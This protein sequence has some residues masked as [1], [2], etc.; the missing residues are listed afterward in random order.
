MVFPSSFP[1]AQDHQESAGLREVPAN[2]ARLPRILSY[3]ISQARKRTLKVAA[4]QNK[5]S[6]SLPP[7]N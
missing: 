3:Y 7:P 6:P 1:E 4:P 2:S 5:T